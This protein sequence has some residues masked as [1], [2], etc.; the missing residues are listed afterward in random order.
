MVGRKH[1]DDIVSKLVLS[2]VVKQR[3]QHRQQGDGGVVDVLGHAFDL[4]WGEKQNI[5]MESDH[6]TVNTQ[7]TLGPVL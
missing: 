1:T 4:L 5:M 7:L 3:G 6:Q 2:D